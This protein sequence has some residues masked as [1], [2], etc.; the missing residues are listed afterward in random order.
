[1]R[2]TKYPRA[3]MK[4]NNFSKLSRSLKAGWKNSILTLMHDDY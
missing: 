4:L 2:I 3:I 1:M